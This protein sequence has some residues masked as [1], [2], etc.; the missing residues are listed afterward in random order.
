[1]LGRTAKISII[2]PV[3]NSRAHLKT[4]LNSI[5]QTIHEY[6]N[7]ELILI[8]NGSTDGSFE[9]LRSDYA[10]LA[11]IYQLRD[12]TISA[13]RNHGARVATGDLLCF[14]DSDFLVP[15]NYLQRA[16]QL[17]ES[18]DTDAAGWVWDLPESSH[19][20]EKTWWTLHCEDRDRYVPYL[21]SGNF[22]IRKK[23]FDEVGGFREDLIT[24]E[25]AELGVRLTANGFRMYESRALAAVNLGNPK[26]LRAFFRTNLWHGLG[27]MGGL[28]YSWFDKTLFLTLLH[29]AL[30]IVG[31]LNLFDSGIGLRGR[32]ARLVLLTSIAPA[33]AVIYRG[34]RRRAMYQP[35]R[36][37]LLYHVYF[38][39]RV[40]AL[41]KLIYL[42]FRGRVRPQNISPRR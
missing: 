35:L 11:K 17:F 7:A 33:I 6:R 31:V 13:L 9:I 32:I 1:M 26:S 15:Q 34:L 20:V 42:R 10:D 21:P 4:C 41:F 23:M 40:S 2:I 37:F 30:T 29:F 5:V 12:V 24:G 39:A 28:S 22:V 36:S 19:W 3:F 8:D 14:I 16:I 27:M 18:V 38:A 25:D